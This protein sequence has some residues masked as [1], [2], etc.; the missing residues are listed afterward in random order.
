MNWKQIL[1][2][3]GIVIMLTIALTFLT[4]FMGL[5]TEYSPR[6]YCIQAP[7]IAPVF[8]YPNWYFIPV[9]A[10]ISTVVVWFYTKY[11]KP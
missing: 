7:C 11:R 5:R 8:Y 4:Y 9:W 1:K 10:G 6:I 2:Y 3:A